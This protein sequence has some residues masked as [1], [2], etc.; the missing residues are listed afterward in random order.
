MMHKLLL[1]LSNKAHCMHTL[2]KQD[3]IKHQLDNPFMNF[4]QLHAPPFIPNHLFL[5]L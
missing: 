2:G 3:Y 4:I 5:P 1:D